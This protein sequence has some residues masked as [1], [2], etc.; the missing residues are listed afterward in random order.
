MFWK[1][2]EKKIGGFAT[3][4]ISSFFLS[5]GCRNRMNKNSSLQCQLSSAASLISVHVC[6]Y[7]R[8]ERGNR[9][10]L[11]DKCQCFKKKSKKDVIS[12]SGK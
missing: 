6:V 5:T 2:K 10:I 4:L 12:G 7:E 1:G 9:R 8:G 3:S 11:L